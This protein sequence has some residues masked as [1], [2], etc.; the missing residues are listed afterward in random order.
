MIDAEDLWN[1]CLDGDVPGVGGAAFHT[2]LSFHSSVEGDSLLGTLEGIVEDEDDDDPF[3]RIDDVRASLDYIGRK[4]VM[5]IVDEGLAFLRTE[6]SD[7][8]FEATDGL[9]TAK[10]TGLLDEDTLEKALRQ[11]ATERPQDFQRT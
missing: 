2:L 7:D 4:D 11:S 6:A 5:D 3:L 1:A 10:V 9:L 8:E